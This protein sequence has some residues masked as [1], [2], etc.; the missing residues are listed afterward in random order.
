MLSERAAGFSEEL[1]RMREELHNGQLQLDSREKRLANVDSSAA[2]LLSER[3]LGFEQSFGVTEAFEY[4]GKYSKKDAEEAGELTEDEMKELA[5]EY[6]G[7]S[8]DSLELEYE[9]EGTSGRRCYSVDDTLICM[10]PRGIESLGQSRLVSEVRM[11]L[12]EAEKRAKDYLKA[13]GYESMELDSV[14]ENGAVALMRFSKTAD[15]AVY[16]DN[17][18]KIGIAMDDGSVYSFNAEHYE[19]ESSPLQWEIEESEAEKSLPSNLK[20]Q[21]SRRVVLE[22][23]NGEETGCYE[24]SCLSENGGEVKVYV[25]A[26]SGKQREIKIA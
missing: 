13:R 5:A 24:L 11:E 7:V 16:L 20:L 18:V 23:E 25:D 14:T 4:G 26:S 19:A 17:Y 22:R 8:P 10:S 6:A 1:G 3:M 2:G 21:D 12:E 9:Y 15:D